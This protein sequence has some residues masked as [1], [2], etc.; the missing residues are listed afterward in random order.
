MAVLPLTPE[1]TKNL[2]ANYSRLMQMAAELDRALYELSLKMMQAYTR[3]A[4]A[5]TE[6]D[7]F[8]MERSTLIERAR[9][10]GR[11]LSKF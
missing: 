11:M 6:L 2:E 5:K 1:E 7:A 10:V 3:Y 9:I 8:K 4:G